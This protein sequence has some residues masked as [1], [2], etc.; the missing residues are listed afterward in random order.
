V[1]DP[2]DASEHPGI[3][4][5]ASYATICSVCLAV[6]A[7]FVG[8]ALDIKNKTS[9]G[10]EVHLARAGAGGAIPTAV[11]L[12]GCAFKPSMISQL[13]GLNVPI[14]AAGLALFYISLKGLG[15][16]K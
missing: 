7:F 3:S 13:S 11:I 5:I 16:I 15:L 14:A 4:Q 10:L 6:L 2:E 12:I 8:V 9:S 1:T